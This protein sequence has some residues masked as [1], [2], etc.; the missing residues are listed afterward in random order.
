[1]NTNYNEQILI[2]EKYINLYN[3]IFTEKKTNKALN[4]YLWDLGWVDNE[5]T[6]FLETEW[7]Q[8]IYDLLDE[9][10]KTILKNKFLLDIREI[11]NNP[12]FNF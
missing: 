4:D 6:S 9:Q 8:Q 10:G 7:I 12:N 5:G 11:I 3:F 2:N 1:M